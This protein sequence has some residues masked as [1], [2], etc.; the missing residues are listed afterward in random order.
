MPG[1]NSA[2]IASGTD[3]QF[4][5]N[6]LII[7]SNITRLTASTFNLQAIGTYL[8]QFQ[9]SINEAGQLCVALNLLKQVYTVVGRAT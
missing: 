3:I 2:T 4:P 7:G 8:V 5:N 6:G 9:V 1:D